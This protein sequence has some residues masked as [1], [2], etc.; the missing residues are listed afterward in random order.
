MIVYIY[1]YKH[2]VTHQRCYAIVFDQIPWKSSYQTVKMA[3]RHVM[4]V[5][6][7]IIICH[8]VALIIFYKTKNYL[9]ICIFL[10]YLISIKE[11]EF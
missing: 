7:I 10:S 5:I 9:S 1:V 8:H 6:I 4:S 3:C 2:H 11:K